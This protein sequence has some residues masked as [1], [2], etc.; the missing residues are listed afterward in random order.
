MATSQSS[1]VASGSR[2]RSRRPAI[3]PKRTVGMTKSQATSPCHLGCVTDDHGIPT[4]PSGFEGVQQRGYEHATT[5]KLNSRPPTSQNIVKPRSASNETIRRGDTAAAGGRSA[6][7]GIAIAPAT[8]TVDASPE[9]QLPRL[10]SP[11]EYKADAKAPQGH[12]F[13][14]LTCIFLKEIQ[15]ALC[16]VRERGRWGL[17]RTLCSGIRVFLC[18]RHHIR[19]LISRSRAVSSL[20]RLR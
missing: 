2:D 13:R 16:G 18:R 4:P 19:S 17:A 10:E 6:A 12:N 14:P 5:A 7:P 3:A 20:C 15:G 8:V 9:Q 11:A 1:L